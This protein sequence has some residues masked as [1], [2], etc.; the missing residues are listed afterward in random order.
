[1]HRFHLAS[2]APLLDYA[3]SQMRLLPC[4]DGTSC[5]HLVDPVSCINAAPAVE[6]LNLG[7]AVVV[8]H[9]DW[10]LDGVLQ[11][12]CHSSFQLLAALKVMKPVLT[13]LQVQNLCTI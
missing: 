3:A 2:P 1:L 12:Q 9:C 10:L 4:V 13:S 11:M 7:H 5:E 8:S 6:H